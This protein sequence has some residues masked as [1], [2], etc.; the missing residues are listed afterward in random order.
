LFT[1]AIAA[2]MKSD[3]SLNLD[4]RDFFVDV[5][6]RVNLEIEY[7]NSHCL[8]NPISQ[9]TES[10]DS[11]VGDFVMHPSAAILASCKEPRQDV[12]TILGVFMRN[13]DKLFS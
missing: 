9:Q 8:I 10:T 6:K 7:F 12:S 3:V 1:A 4:H 11:T 13:P 5:R 2:T